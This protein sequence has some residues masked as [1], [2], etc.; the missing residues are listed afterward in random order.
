[1]CCACRR[2][3]LVRCVVEMAS[4]LHASKQSLSRP[5]SALD[6]Q[7]P[8]AEELDE[9]LLQACCTLYTEQLAGTEQPL[10]AGIIARVLPD[11]DPASLYSQKPHKLLFAVC[12]PDYYRTKCA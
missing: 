10:D 2:I 9:T 1:M 6:L 7:G 5:P 3:A 8:A 12:A 4:R 11:I